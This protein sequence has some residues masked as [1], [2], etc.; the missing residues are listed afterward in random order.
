MVFHLKIKNIISE[1]RLTRVFL[2]VGLFLLMSGKGMIAGGTGI[3]VAYDVTSDDDD[4]IIAVG[5]T[6]MRIIP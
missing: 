3:Q 6:V 4:N 1:L 2:L 5:K